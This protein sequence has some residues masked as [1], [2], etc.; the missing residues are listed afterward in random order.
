ML[1]CKL[2]DTPMDP[3]VK[4]VPGQGGFYEIQGDIDN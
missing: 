3:N 2:I 4:L 1:D